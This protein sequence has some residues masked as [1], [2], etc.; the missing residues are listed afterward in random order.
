M[1][2]D[3]NKLVL[4]MII[5]VMASFILATT[6]TAGQPYHRAIRGQYAA[7][8]GGTC[9]V[10]FLGFE[11]LV[12]KDGAYVLMTFSMEAVFTFYRDG[13]GHV[14]RTNPTVIH[15][16]SPFAPYPCAGISK[17]SW[18]FTYE[19]K[20]DG[21]ITL[22]EVPGSHSGEFTSGPWV[23][24][25]EYHDEGRNWRGTVSPDGK[26][27]ILNGGLDDI[28]TSPSNPGTEIICNVSAVLTWQHN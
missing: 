20:R 28:I 27:I 6:V 11:N 19:V 17:D 23:A 1:K 16:P 24:L 4:L 18:D 3:I 5:I 15:N 9:F 8:G 22:T 13:T 2:G 21:S 7:T 25:G 12:P 26:T 10:A 14:E